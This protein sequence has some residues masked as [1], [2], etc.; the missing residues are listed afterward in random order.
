[1]RKPIL[2]SLVVAVGLVAGCGGDSAPTKAEYI[3][4]ADPICE[5]ADREKQVR[6]EK[7]FLENPEP[8]SGERS[9]K[10]SAEFATDFSAEAVTPFLRTQ[11]DELSELDTPSEEG[12][13]A[14]AIVEEF[15]AAVAK[16]EDNPAA[17]AIK[18]D[19]FEKAAE[20]ADE[21]GFKECLIDY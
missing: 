1:M 4:E 11:V 12:E 5:K 14:E 10:Q 9:V 2:V 17:L 15:D 13:K 7:F 16:L 3:A 6:I 18:P 8:P 20:M 19:P 21:F